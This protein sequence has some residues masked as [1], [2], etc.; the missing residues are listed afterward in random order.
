MTIFF[1]MIIAGPSSFFLG[2]TLYVV[3]IISKIISAICS[4]QVT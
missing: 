3:H 4:W 2:Y 1:A